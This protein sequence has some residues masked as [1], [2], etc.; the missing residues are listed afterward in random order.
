MEKPLSK[1]AKIVCAFLLIDEDELGRIINEDPSWFK[2]DTQGGE[3]Y[4]KVDN[5]P[6]H[7]ESEK[8]Y[9]LEI[10]VE[11]LDKLSRL[12]DTDDDV[13]I[14]LHRQRRK[15]RGESL[16]DIAKKSS[17]PLA[18]YNGLQDLID[19]IQKWFKRKNIN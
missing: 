11:H 2:Q 8:R 13:L 19:H 7:K 3:A 12:F 4:L 14:F 15:L 16:A 1:N 9:Q 18:E 17:S 10:L 5:S 6:F